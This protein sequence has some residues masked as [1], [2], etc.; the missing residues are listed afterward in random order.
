MIMSQMPAKFS[1]SRALLDELYDDVSRATGELSGGDQLQLTTEAINQL[2]MTEVTFGNPRA[3][4]ARLTPKLFEEIGV[5]LT[6]L[7]KRQLREQFNYY[8]MALAVSMQP[9]RGV[10]FSRLE[11]R[12]EFGPKGAQ[13]PIVLSLSP[14]SAWRDVL[15]WGGGMQLA[16]DGDLK[17]HLRTPRLP[18]GVTPDSLPEF[19][20]A[21]LGTDDHMRSFVAVHDF[22]FN[23]GRAEIA[24]TGEGN[25]LCFWRIEKPELKEV[26]TVKFGIVFKVPKTVEAIKMVGTVIAEP[27]M[28]WLTANVR[29]V[30]ESL[31]ERLQGLLRKRDEDRQGAE[32]LPLGD[33]ERWVLSL[34]K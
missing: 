1:E 4:L 9:G 30:F 34:P 6:E 24:A 29:D 22:S 18:E 11:C 21:G 10:Q 26:Q 25:S 19:V 23:M 20:E 12:L 14:T 16:L 28:A 3:E 8:T 33:H 2:R 31:S 15:S 17:W 32:R 5:E 7:Q 13:E 27:D